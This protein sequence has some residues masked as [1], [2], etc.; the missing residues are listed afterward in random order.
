MCMG[1]VAVLAVGRGL[2]Y[3]REIMGYLGLVEI[4]S[5]ET[6][7]SGRVDD[8]TSTHVGWQSEHLAEGGRVHAGVVHG[9]Y[10]GGLLLHLSL[11][12][13]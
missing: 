5:A 6:F 11:I 10:F 12:H 9:G 8:E 1:A 4:Y 7:H 13:I 2:E 3:L